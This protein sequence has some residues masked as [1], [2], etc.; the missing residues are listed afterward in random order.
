MISFENESILTNPIQYLYIF[1]Q[2]NEKF[3]QN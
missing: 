2:K 1:S 3:F